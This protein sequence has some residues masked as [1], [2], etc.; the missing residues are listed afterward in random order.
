MLYPYAPSHEGT[1]MPWACIWWVG[2]VHH[3]SIIFSINVGVSLLLCSLFPSCHSSVLCLSPFLLLLYL[4]FELWPTPLFDSWKGWRGF[5]VGIWGHSKGS[6]PSYLLL[7]SCFGPIL[8]GLYK[9]LSQILSALL[10]IT[11][12]V[13]GQAGQHVSICVGLSRS[14][15]Y[16][17]PEVRNL[18]TGYS[19]LWPASA[20]WNHNLWPSSY[21]PGADRVQHW[22]PVLR[23]L[24]VTGMVGGS[25]WCTGWLSSGCHETL[26]HH[27]SFIRWVSFNIFSDWLNAIYWGFK[28]KV[29]LFSGEIHL[30]Q[31]LKMQQYREK[32]PK[33]MHEVK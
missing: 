8:G 22:G 28:I 20:F 13:E 23:H 19:F 30:L 18:C 21:C 3:L 4:P 16:V 6:H 17:E 1:V 33:N 9:L 27:I 12:N 5:L 2:L 7:L 26:A 32:N 29:Y 11:I 24:C 14:I 25:L 10:H 15:F 31:Q